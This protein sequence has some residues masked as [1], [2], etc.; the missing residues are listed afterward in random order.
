M[1][2]IK[3][4]YLTMLYIITVCADADPTNLDSWSLPF[5]AFHPLSLF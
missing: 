5:G 4:M 2:T 3:R 1:K